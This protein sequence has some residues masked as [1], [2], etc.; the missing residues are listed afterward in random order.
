VRFGR[1]AAPVRGSPLR[2]SPRLFAAGE[3]DEQPDDEPQKPAVVQAR[4][5]TR[6]RT[7]RSR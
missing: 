6:S 4:P 5:S 2:S 1:G 7:G 3:P